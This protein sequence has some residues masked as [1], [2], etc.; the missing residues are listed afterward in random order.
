MSDQ[1]TKAA[2]EQ[3]KL[4]EQRMQFGQKHTEVEEVVEELKDK[5]GKVLLC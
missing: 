5:L 4:E 2:K 1:G 3:Q